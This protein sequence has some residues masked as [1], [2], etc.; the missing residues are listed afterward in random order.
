MWI[1]SI[2]MR[3]ELKRADYSLP[4]LGLVAKDENFKIQTVERLVKP[5]A[6]QSHYSVHKL[7]KQRV[8]DYLF[9]TR[10]QR[11]FPDETLRT[12]GRETMVRYF[13][14]ER[15]E[16]YTEAQ[17]MYIAPISPVAN[18][19]W[20]FWE[21]R[22]ELLQ[23]SADMDLANPSLWK[24]TAL[25]LHVFN[26]DEDVVASRVEVSGSNAYVTKDWVGRVLYNCIVLGQKRTVSAEE[27][28]RIDAELRGKP[29]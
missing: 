7:P 24:H 28:N 18:R 5:P 4:E 12:R 29:K 26:L 3:L 14:E 23:F 20:V 17:V 21:N 15:K 6:R 25:M 10:N 13:R 11:L 1:P 8:V 27:A 22:R 9:Q 16:P 19:I 2:K